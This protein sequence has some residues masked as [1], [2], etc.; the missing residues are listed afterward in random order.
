MAKTYY[1]NEAGVKAFGKKLRDI[2]KQ[3]GISQEA[4]AYAT[5]L[6]LS[7][8]GRIERS[9]VNTS[10]SFVYLFCKKSSKFIPK[11]FLNNYLSTLLSSRPSWSVADLTESIT[12]VQ[13]KLQP[14]PCTL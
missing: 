5:D 13:L 3:K 14:A 12:A 10:I 6:H 9:E 4:L 1:K 7:Q 8:V 11:I 2:R